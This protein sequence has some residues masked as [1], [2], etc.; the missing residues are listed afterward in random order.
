MSATEHSPLGRDVAYPRRFDAGLLYPIPRALGRAA[1]GVGARAR[2]VA[3][4]PSRE[5]D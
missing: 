3:R 1:I 4:A 5:A 2:A